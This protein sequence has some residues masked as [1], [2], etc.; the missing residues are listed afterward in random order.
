MPTSRGTSVNATSIHRRSA[1]NRINAIATNPA[2]NARQI[3]DQRQHCGPWSRQQ[4]LYSDGINPL[5]HV[6]RD[7]SKT[8]PAMIVRHDCCYL[9]A[10][11]PF[12]PRVVMG[13]NAQVRP[14][15]PIAGQ[16][17]SYAVEG[18]ILG[19]RA[20]F[21][22]STYRE[23]KC[24]PSDQFD[25][26][27]WCQ[28]TRRE[29]ERRGSFEATSSMLHGKD[30]TVVYVNRH[31]QPA[32][33]DGKEADRNIQNYSRKFAESPK[34]IKIPRRA[35]NADA[36]LATWGKIEL[37]PL[38][39]D[40]VRLL[41][42]GKSPKKGLLI[43]F[44][45]NLSRSARDGLPIYRIVGGAGFVWAGSFDQKGRGTLR[46]AAV[47]PSTLQ[48]EPVAAQ[49]SNAAIKGSRDAEATIA[50]LQTE[51]SAAIKAKAEAD[52]ARTD[53]EK[54]A[55]QARRD[56]EIARNDAN[57][58]IDEIDRLKGGGRPPTSYVKGILIG[59]FA[60]A[61]LVVVIW[62]FSKMF[63]VS[64]KESTD[65]GKADNDLKAHT[66]DVEGAIVSWSTASESSAETIPS[67]DQDDLL[68]QLAKT[69]GALDTVAPSPAVIEGQEQTQA[70]TS[71][72][73]TP[74]KKAV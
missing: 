28:K 31:Q 66:D 34:I 62:T 9:A 40:G 49:S 73:E 29:S 67:I 25:G 56:A 20:K 53:A 13:A 16:V 58:A 30:G 7:A 47:D 14:G 2:R 17:P 51:L 19:S 54:A 68:K 60:T 18:L 42:E 3:C 38:D 74:S 71:G 35:G 33:F 63:K 15:D 23:Y 52:L 8:V 72:E 5:N 24:A 32:F 50:R 59:I 12:Y 21:D 45:G 44:L 36:V 43:D 10:I 22:S 4:L 70:N 37:E 65:A 26:Y 55:Q 39:D 1:I 27:T 69:L 61:I 64:S 46:F 41:T 57:V 48:L 6:S 11:T